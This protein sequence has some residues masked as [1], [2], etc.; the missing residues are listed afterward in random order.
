MMMVPEFV[1]FVRTKFD[2]RNQ[3]KIA[4]ALPSNSIITV[5]SAHHSLSKISRIGVS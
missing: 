2:D 1:G 5:S 3:I 4:D